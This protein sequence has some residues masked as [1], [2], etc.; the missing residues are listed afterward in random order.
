MRQ[1]PDKGAPRVKIFGL[2]HGLD[3]GM[4]VQRRCLRLG[5]QLVIV[6]NLRMLASTSSNRTPNPCL[7][8]I[9]MP[10]AWLQRGLFKGTITA[11]HELVLMHP[12]TGRVRG[13]RCIGDER[14]RPVSHPP[15][16]Q[17]RTA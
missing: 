13:E 10:V 4:W 7:P 5:E 15:H 9:S 14:P 17:W 3:G 2:D 12:E 16:H 11:V 6:L 1:R 8:A